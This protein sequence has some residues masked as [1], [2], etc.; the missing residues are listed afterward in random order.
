MPDGLPENKSEEDL[1]RPGGHTNVVPMKKLR[2]KTSKRATWPI[3]NALG[4]LREMR[5]NA[6]SMIIADP[7]SDLTKIRGSHVLCMNYAIGVVEGIN[8]MKP[9][10]PP[11]FYEDFLKFTKNFRN[12]LAD[13]LYTVADY[14]RAP[15]K[16][17][18]D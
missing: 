12:A 7:E 11:T 3:D 13:L 15:N 4:G 1:T 2:S 17:D 8:T 16:W 9:P 5:D 14:I 6:Q 18:E 10:A